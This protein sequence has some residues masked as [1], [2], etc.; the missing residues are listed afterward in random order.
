MRTRVG[1]PTQFRVNWAHIK[2]QNSVILAQCTQTRVHAT[3]KRELFN[4]L[5]FSLLKYL[6]ATENFF[7]MLHAF[8]P[9]IGVFNERRCANASRC[10]AGPFVQ[11]NRALKRKKH[12]AVKEDKN[13]TRASAS[14]QSARFFFND[15]KLSQ[16]GIRIIL[17]KR[18]S[19]GRLISISRCLAIKL[20]IQVQMRLLCRKCLMLRF[21]S[22]TIT[23]GDY[24]TSGASRAIRTTYENRIFFREPD[25]LWGVEGVLRR[26]YGRYGFRV[27]DICCFSRSNIGH[28][29]FYVRD[30]CQKKQRIREILTWTCGFR[31]IKDQ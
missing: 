16:A 6:S 13:I 23:G 31:R 15:A 11:T 5:Q 4:L 27:A 17:Q 28:R 30:A 18:L 22:K 21:G 19:S 1:N 14:Q 8:P 25:L 12:I 26:V 7:R 29:S 3:F 24:S 2:P 9:C 10:L 20:K